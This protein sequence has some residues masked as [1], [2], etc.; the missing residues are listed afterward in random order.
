MTCIATF[1]NNQ[2]KSL[3]KIPTPEM[4]TSGARSIGNSMR[5]E[6]H[7]E[8]ARECWKAMCNSYLEGTIEPM[9]KGKSK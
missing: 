2:E 6:N 1:E 9:P 3:P 5:E 4:L 7:N 8:R